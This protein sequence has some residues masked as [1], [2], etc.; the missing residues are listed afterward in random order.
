MWSYG[1]DASNWQG[2]ID[3]NTV[4]Q[5]PQIEFCYFLAS[6]GIYRGRPPSAPMS[7]EDAFSLNTRRC[8]KPRGAYHFARFSLNPFECAERFVNDTAL[9]HLELPPA[10]D[11]EE[12]DNIDVR[13]MTLDYIINWC[14]LWLS[15]VI[16]LT[17]RQPIIYNGDSFRTTGLIR[18]FPEYTWW[19][20]QY[21]GNTRI[22]PDPFTLRQPKVKVNRTPDIWQ[23]TDKGRVPGINGNVD[24]NL[25]LR[26]KLWE[27]IEVSDM[28]LDEIAKQIAT[29]CGSAIYH[30][31]PH[32]SPRMRHLSELGI[33]QP[34][35]DTTVE[36][37][38]FQVFSDFTMVQ[39]TGDEVARLTSPY[40]NVPD[41]GFRNDSWWDLL[42]V[43]Y[44][45]VVT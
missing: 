44:R 32:T 41:H 26:T 8:K 24:M 34:I 17:G 43:T 5:N 22:N 4:N 25:A 12:Y 38:A 20:P 30:V 27:L 10:L 11:I 7:I 40:L 37:W 6:D 39:R 23:Y 33:L 1:I 2:F 21:T 3:W 31:N 15:T 28:T 45:D 16:A 36:D 13:N 14:K 9:L 29:M 35:N 18:Y 42:R 19:L